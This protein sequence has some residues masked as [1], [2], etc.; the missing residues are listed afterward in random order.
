MSITR[1][2]TAW[3]TT[4]TPVVSASHQHSDPHATPSVTMRE[5]PTP[6][7]VTR[8]ALAK[9][10]AKAMIVIGLVNVSPTA[11]V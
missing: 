5:L 3:R 9:T 10:A 8:P 4:H 1:S 7:C 11:L 6:A 2:L